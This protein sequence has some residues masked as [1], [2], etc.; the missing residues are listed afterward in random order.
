MEKFEILTE[1]FVLPEQILQRIRYSLRNKVSF[2]LVRIGD[3]ENQILA[4]GVIYNEKQIN[5][6]AWAN[7]ENYTGITLPNYEARDK[8]IQSLKKADMV[9]VLDRNEVY[10][11][12]PLTEK[13]FPIYDIRPKQICSAFVNTNWPDNYEF[14]SL[15]KSCRLL[16]IG[17]PAE[18]FAQFLYSRYR[19]NT[20][21]AI[22]IKNYSEITDV[23]S[24][25]SNIDYDLALLSAGSNAVILAAELARRGKVAIDFGH[26]MDIALWKKKELP[27]HMKVASPVNGDPRFRF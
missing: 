22:S 12:K 25:T 9:G 14:I 5:L 13:L 16:L 3:A 10:T 17:K 4:Q 15:M 23:L 21:A 7:D 20:A 18:A 11:W 1:D 27:L 19:V 26:A 24:R 8:M 2:S 6:I